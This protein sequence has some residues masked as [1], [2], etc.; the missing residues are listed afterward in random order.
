MASGSE[1]NTSVVAFEGHPEILSTQLRLLP[2]SPHVLVLP[3]IRSY[4]SAD[5][6]R[7]FDTH[8]YIKSVHDAVKIRDQS[9][10]DFLQWSTKSSKRLVFLNGGT[11]TAQTLCMKAIAKHQTDGDERKAE[12]IF[13]RLVKDGVAGLSSPIAES[14]QLLE[15]S[16]ITQEVDTP[17]PNESTN[18][19]NEQQ[20][21]VNDKTAPLQTDG[22]S[23]NESMVTRSIVHEVEEIDVSLSHHEEH[24]DPITRAMQAADA[25]DRQTESLQPSNDLDLTIS[26]RPRSSSLPLY[27]IPENLG[28]STP[29]YVFG[30]QQREETD[31]AVEYE[32]AEAGPPMGYRPT[33]AVFHYEQSSDNTTYP[34]FFDQLSSPSSPVGTEERHAMIPL[35]TPRAFDVYTPFSD[36]FGLR[37]P[38]NVVFGEASLLDVRKSGRKPSLARIRSLDRIYSKTSR[39]RDLCIPEEPSD[40]DSEIDSP[41]RQP[42]P[43]SCILVTNEK[44][45]L[46]SRI[47]I[48]DG[49]RAIVVRPKNEAL[50][51]TVAP[52]PLERRRRRRMARACYIDRGTDAAEELEF[53]SDVVPGPFEP[54][55]PLTEDLIIY[56]R[57]ESPD[58]LLDRCIHA[59]KDG[60]Y[61]IVAPAITKQQAPESNEALPGTPESQF[62]RGTGK[63]QQNDAEDIGVGSA[64]DTDDYDPFA[65]VHPPKAH[66]KNPSLTPVV[67]VVSP[68]TPEQTPTPSVVEE[69]KFRNFEILSTHTTVAV[70]NSLRSLLGEYFPPEA[71]CYHQ[72]FATALP[73]LNAPWQPVFRDAE[74][75]L[76]GNKGR[77]VDQILA[78]GS[79]KGVQP[80]FSSAITTQLEKIGSKASGVCCSGRLDFR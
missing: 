72:F 19:V 63:T 60:K 40:G 56:L 26:S 3:E 53:A 8:K 39:L 2:A 43:Q 75:Q 5:A 29:F 35:P 66:I 74:P 28:E 61:P 44:D 15:Q 20:E 25:L 21:T 68:P 45:Q 41:S 69:E 31:T 10:R 59:F 50:T 27:G 67:K 78:I 9:A 71:Q 79:Q 70:Q 42:R 37:S 16:P 18:A 14:D 76:L 13:D 4:L 33:F 80:A 24:Q 11:P 34:G 47:D 57:D 77:N 30:P 55:F 12:A 49:P 52:V 6:E 65:Y 48:I 51:V 23:N 73:E 7:D 46:M 36:T 54:T 38:E 32:A 17:D 64:P 1:F 22:S 58:T 62:L